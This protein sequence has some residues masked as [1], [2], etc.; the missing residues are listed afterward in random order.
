MDRLPAL[1]ALTLLLGACEEKPAAP[2]R[3]RVDAVKARGGNKGNV[4]SFCDV[5]PKPGTR[6]QLPALASA[7]PAAT[8]WRWVNVWATWCTPCVEEI[9][10]LLRWRD[11]LAAAGKPISLVFLS[12]D[13]TD[14]VVQTFRRGHPA[15]PEGPRIADPAALPAWMQTLGLDAAAPI[16]VHV[17]VA[18]GGEIRCVRAGGVSE[19]D[20]AVAAGLLGDTR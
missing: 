6:F 18:P 3:S 5:I 9:P 4:E 11:K 19:P 15:L 17:L 13:E 7:A 10:L 12:V 2:P 20:Y 1:I 16:P 8:G 14:E